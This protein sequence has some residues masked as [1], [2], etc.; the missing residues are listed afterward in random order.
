[1]IYSRIKSLAEVD[2]ELLTETGRE[3]ESQVDK[4]FVIWKLCRNDGTLIGIAGLYQ[5][6]L[7]SFTPLLWFIP[8]KTLK[9]LDWRG[10]KEAITRLQKLTPNMTAKV[11][12]H[13]TKAVT[14]IKHTK[15]ISCAEGIYKWI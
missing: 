4:S 2:V 15:A 6:S 10:I 13:D 14:F 8:A 9:P 12:E 7:L 3:E 5:F 1:M 11:N